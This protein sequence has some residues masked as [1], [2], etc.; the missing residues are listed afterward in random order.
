M[1]FGLYWRPAPK[2]VPPAHDLPVDLKYVLARRLW[3][4]D[5][6]LRGEAVLTGTIIPYLE[7]IAD[8]RGN[9]DA[10]EGARELIKAIKEHGAVELW[11][12]DAD[13]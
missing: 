3:G 4:H 10:A 6:T 1:S 11:I 7:G 2:E 13:D 12:G 5:G 9:S 8:A